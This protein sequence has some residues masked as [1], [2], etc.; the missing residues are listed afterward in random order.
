MSEPKVFLAMPYTG[1]ASVDA[2]LAAFYTATR[3]KDRMVFF[4]QDGPAGSHCE[5]FNSLWCKALNSRER[6]GWTH[7]AMIHSDVLPEEWWLDTLLVEMA[8]AHADVLSV[9]LA[10]KDNRGVTSTALQ[11]R[12][13]LYTHRLTM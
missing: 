11:D 13:T 1:S 3:V 4:P 9:V 10:I 7:F 5:N 2:V 8:R 12:E 6:D